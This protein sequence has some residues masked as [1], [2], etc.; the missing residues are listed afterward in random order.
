MSINNKIK[1][2]NL[3]ISLIPL[4]LILGNLAININVIIIC[5]LG[6]LLYGK[7]N[8]FLED[9]IYQYLIYIF[10]FYIIIITLYNNAFNFNESNLY[11]VNFFK[12]LFLL[13]FLI[14]FLIIN[15]LIANNALNF[16][17]FYIS[18]AFFSFLISFDLLFQV[19]FKKN[20][21]GLEISMHRPSSFFG[22]ENIAG[23]Y[24]QKFI[25][26]FIFFCALS[27]KITN[28]ENL[29]FI[30][31]IIFS[32][33]IIITVNRM[34]VLI[35]LS[36]FMFFLLIHKSFKQIF[37]AIFLL[38][39]IILFLIKIQVVDRIEAQF[40]IF[41]SDTVHLITSAPKLFLYNQYDGGLEIGPSGYLFHFNS[42]IQIWKKNKI[43]GHGLKS[44]PLNCKYGDYQTCNTH[45]H[46]YVIEIM[47]DTGI[48]GLVSIYSLFIIALLKFIKFYF[49]N[50][51][52][53]SKFMLL[54][55]FFIIFFEFFPFRSSGSFF[56]TGNAVIIFLFLSFFINFK[57]INF[58]D[59]NYK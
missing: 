18:C 47:V 57:K 25:L 5:I 11:K 4:S 56:T 46:N 12:S 20:L 42:G 34:S 14:L 23:G 31:F 8:F 39:S 27:K 40:N 17:L 33:P 49:S 28:K 54:P 19:I 30:L 45:P 32:I 6:L 15:Q 44:F 37:L 7:K 58:Q 10:F 38:I 48:I 1:L 29:L 26:F 52:K 24:L 3:F 2:L 55:I 36:T 22:E 50:K 53:R 59:L 21:I 16:K 43:F 41:K 35:Y 51:N 13:R 9:K